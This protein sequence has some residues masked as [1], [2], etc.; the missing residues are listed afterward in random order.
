MTLLLFIPLFAAI[1]VLSS[2]VM[3]G[4]KAA[5]TPP[6]TPATPTAAAKPA[7]PPPPV[8][9]PQTQVELPPP[10]PVSPAALATIPP[11]REDLPTQ[12]TEPPAKPPTRKPAGPQQVTNATKPETP[13]AA[14]ETPPPVQG[15]PTAP[16]TPVESQRLKPVYSEEERR[17][18][19]AELEKRKSDIES[20]LSRLNQ[21][22]MS[23]EQKSVVERIRS[24]INIADESAKGGDFRAAEAFA[25][26]ALIFARELASGR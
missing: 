20:I 18:N 22:R 6:P 21:N 1:L 24:F 13:P 8:S 2:C 7:T 17:R 16:V 14:A 25:E 10:Q 19:M 26:R 9:T 23:A 5:K 15:P 4:S 11:A 12:E 3:S